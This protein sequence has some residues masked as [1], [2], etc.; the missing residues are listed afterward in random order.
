MQQAGVRLLC[1]VKNLANIGPREGLAHLRTYFAT[2]GKLLGA[3]REHPPAAAVLI[4]F[5]EFN[6]R[7]AKRLKRAGIPVIYYISPQLWAWR[8]GRIKLVRKYVDEMLVILPFEEDYYRQ[9]GVPVRF[10]GHPLLEDFAPTFDRDGFLRALN[11]EPRR[12]TVALLPGSRR[13]EVE[14]MLP[15]MLGAALEI[16]RQMPTQFVISAAPTVGPNYLERIMAA[17]MAGCMGG[18]EFRISQAPSRDILA[19]ADFALVK[20]G[21]STLEAALVGTPFLVT[22]KISAAS[23]LVNRFIHVPFRGLV[24][25]IAQEEVAPELLQDKATPHALAQTA[26]QYLQ[27]SAR[28]QAMRTRLAEIRSM[29]GARPATETVADVIGKYL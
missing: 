13:K 15:S 11:L 8:S 21:T 17:E 27:D 20:S 10:V 12:T 29:L 4:D 19:N 22:Y 9:R 14:Y 16:A 5:P 26:L 24:N 28:A 3:A 23:W 2:F 7:L 1:H 25:L 6:L 18:P